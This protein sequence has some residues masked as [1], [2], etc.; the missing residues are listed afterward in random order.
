MVVFVLSSQVKSALTV[1]VLS[2]LAGCGSEHVALAP[3][4]RAQGP[5]VV[6][7]PPRDPSQPESLAEQS[8]HVSIEMYTAVW[9][10]TCQVAKRW[11]SANHVAYQEIDIDRQPGARDQL[12]TLNPARS[13]PTFDINGSVYVGF[14][15][16]VMTQMIATAAQ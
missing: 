10:G 13:I 11:L 14:N 3:A 6:A 12:R 1:L 5:L 8:A 4:E 7:A 2:V 15:P 16:N 9:C